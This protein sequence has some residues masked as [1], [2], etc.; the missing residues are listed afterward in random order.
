MAK[1]PAGTPEDETTA[2]VTRPNVSAALALIDD[3]EIPMILAENFGGGEIDPRQLPTIKIPS[4]GQPFW[5]IPTMEGPK[6]A[7]SFEGVVIYWANMRGYWESNYNENPNSPPVCTSRDG[8]TGIGAPGGSCAACRFNQF[9][10]KVD[11]DQPSGFGAGKACREQRVMFVLRDGQIIPTFVPLA[12]MSIKP[13]AEYF[14]LLSTNAVPYYRVMTQFSL[15]EATSGGGQKYSKAKLTMAR[16]LTAEENEIVANYRAKLLPMFQTI[17]VG[18]VFDATD[19][20][21][22]YRAGDDAG[23]V[24][25]DTFDIDPNAIDA[26]VVDQPTA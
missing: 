4:G 22:N 15:V 26:D 25:G 7:E 18:Q 16:R 6:P 5:T 10:T 21:N 12:T 23:E 20:E 19:N 17:P 3:P 24:R 1:T 13:A 11:R 2:I 14:A 9:N 8:L